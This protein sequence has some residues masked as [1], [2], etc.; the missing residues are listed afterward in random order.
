MHFTA[1]SCVEQLTSITHAYAHVRD[2]PTLQQTQVIKHT[3]ITQ[4]LRLQLARTTSRMPKQAP[5][6]CAPM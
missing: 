2:Q 5:D 4:L 6:S 1:A 3:F